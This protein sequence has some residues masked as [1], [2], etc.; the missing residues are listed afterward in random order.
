MCCGQISKEATNEPQ[1]NI[2][3]QLL[4]GDNE[5]MLHPSSGEDR[6]NT[7]YVRWENRKKK[8]MALKLATQPSEWQV[9]CHNI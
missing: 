5:S 2:K 9:E 8:T 4:G 7:I 1:P 3:Q 6:E